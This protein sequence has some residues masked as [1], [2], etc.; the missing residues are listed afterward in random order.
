MLGIFVILDTISFYL[1]NVN[2]KYSKVPFVFYILLLVF[3]FYFVFCF[4][5]AMFHSYLVSTNQTTHEIFYKSSLPYIVKYKEM[6]KVRMETM[7]IKVTY[8]IPFA[9]FDMGIKE[10]LKF[11]YYN[12][13]EYDWFKY[14][15]E[16]LQSNKQKFNWCENEYW[17]CF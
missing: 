9:P 10:N 8:N 17:S 15:Y 6:K 4:I 5:L 11:I 2:E 13:R 7:G 14:L 3:L 1:D 12:K 16:N